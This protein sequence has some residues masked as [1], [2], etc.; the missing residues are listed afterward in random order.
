[1]NLLFAAVVGLALA[2]G[3]TQEMQPRVL[4]GDTSHCDAVMVRNGHLAVEQVCVKGSGTQH[5]H[6][7]AQVAWDGQTATITDA[8]EKA[9]QEW[10][11][12]HTLLPRLS[13]KHDSLYWDDKKVDLGKVDVWDLYEAIPW[14]GGVLVYGSTVPHKG[15]FGQ[16]PFK[17]PSST[18]ERWSCTV[19]S[20]SIPTRSRGKI[21]TST[22]KRIEAFSSS[23]SRIKS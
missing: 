7:R 18:F 9:S 4:M 2:L 12:T 20:S 11:R 8:D 16:W 10:I 15:F 3:A 19:Q 13:K 1:M 14:Q 6:F 22:E 21:Y 17:G 23:L 5:N